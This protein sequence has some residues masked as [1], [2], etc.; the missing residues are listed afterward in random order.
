MHG[1][2][3]FERHAHSCGRIDEMA[4]QILKLLN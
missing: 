4:I 3:A 1:L 2:G